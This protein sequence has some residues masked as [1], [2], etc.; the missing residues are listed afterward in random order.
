MND[1]LIHRTFGSNIENENFTIVG[2]IL[3]Y[4]VLTPDAEAIIANKNIT[5]YKQLANMILSISSGL[6]E[7]GILRGENILIEAIHEDIFP[8]CCYAVQLLGAVVVP[9]EK[10]VPKERIREI[11]LMTDAKIVISSKDYG[12]EDIKTLTFGSLRSIC[13]MVKFSKD[14]VISFPNPDSPCEILFTT[15]TTG[16]SKGVVITHRNMSWYARSVAEAVKMKNGNRFLIAAPLNHAG[17]IRRT[18][19]SLANGCC[20]VYL[21]GIGNLSE[22]YRCIKEYAVT[23][24]YL[25]PV[26][27]RILLARTSSELAKYDGQIDFVYSSSSVLYENEC[28]A[29]RRILPSAR[30]YNAYETS[31]TPGVSVYD[32]NDGRLINNCIGK[33]NNGVRIG[34]M[35]KNGEITSDSN[36]KGHICVKSVMNMKEYYHDQEL[37]DSVIND[38]WFISSDIGTIDNEGNL[39]FNGRIGN[40]IN[41]CGY[42]ISPEEIEEIVMMSG[43]VN[44]TVCIEEK[45]KYGFQFLKLLVV[46]KNK[47]IFDNAK[48]LSFIADRLEAYKIPRIIETVDFIYRTFNGKIDRKRYKN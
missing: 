48:L 12:F 7:E 23:S 14:M 44:E 18:H 9:V 2:S 27:I 8:A 43:M 36:I 11:A 40:V 38:G 24:L 22:Y 42:K 32:Y 10:S 21:N 19:M 15:G 31:E 25:P 30:L 3:K 5:T 33:A 17:G 39:I 6:C 45:D 16:M 29:L 46:V 1:N 41:I 35:S 37:T 28:K 4:S 47:E 13:G 26:A 20:V 34:I